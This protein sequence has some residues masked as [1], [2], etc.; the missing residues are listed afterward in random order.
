MNDTS[1]NFHDGDDDDFYDFVDDGNENDTVVALYSTKVQQ[2][3]VPIHLF[4]TVNCDNDV[5]YDY[6]GNENN[7][8]DDE[9]DDVGTLRSPRVEQNV[10]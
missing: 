7:D 2:K 10:H 1:D 3:V 8:D 5:D 6:D 4:F 9:N